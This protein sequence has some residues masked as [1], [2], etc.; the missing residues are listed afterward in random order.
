M[1]CSQGQKKRSFS[2]ADFLC[3]LCRPEY[4]NQDSLTQAF[5]MSDTPPFW[6]FR[7][8][9]GSVDPWSRPYK[10]VVIDPLQTLSWAVRILHPQKKIIEW[11][12]R[13]AIKRIPVETCIEMTFFQWSQL[14]VYLTHWNNLVKPAWV[15]YFYS[16]NSLWAVQVEMYCI[17][18]L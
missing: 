3:T 17:S 15:Y 5:G 10:Y 7:V 6:H 13:F 8:C 12:W 16:K 14:V 9:K 4:P 1:K 11:M 2:S 18:L